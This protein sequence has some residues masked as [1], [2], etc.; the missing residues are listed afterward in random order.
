MREGGL[1]LWCGGADWGCG[2]VGEYGDCDRRSDRLEGFAKAALAVVAEI[3]TWYPR[4]LK[5]DPV[6]PGVQTLKLFASAYADHPD[7]DPAWRVTS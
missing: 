6:T 4:G 3:L 5:L 2:G 7:F 1:G